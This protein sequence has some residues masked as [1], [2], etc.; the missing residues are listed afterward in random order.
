[1]VGGWEWLHGRPWESAAD[2]TSECAHLSPKNNQDNPSHKKL[3]DLHLEKY[4]FP[5]EMMICLPNGTVVGNPRHR[6]EP[7][8][9]PWAR[10]SG[11]QGAQ[12]CTPPQALSLAP[13][14]P[15]GLLASPSPSCPIYKTGIMVPTLPALY[16]C[17]DAPVR[18]GT[19]VALWGPGSNEH[20]L[21]AEWTGTWA[22][23]EGSPWAIMASPRMEG[24]G[25]AR[26]CDRHRGPGE[27]R[28]GQASRHYLL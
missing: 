19:S 15:A 20:S 28:P 12:A 14:L 23:K 18:R 1:M 22:G 2:E 26:P 6:A 21:A 17:Q 13:L 27:A 9:R 7:Q 5:V 8:V 16:G 25:R 3:A 10:G 24:G 11:R 4:S